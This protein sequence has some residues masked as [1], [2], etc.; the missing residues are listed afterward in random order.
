MEN[1]ITDISFRY[2]PT[3]EECTI[4]GAEISRILKLDSPQTIYDWA[5]AFSDY[6]SIKKVDGR[7]KFSKKSLDEFKFIQSLRKKDWSWKQIKEHISKRGFEFAQYDSGLIN[8]NDPMGYEALAVQISMKNEIMLQ[9]FLKTLNQ[10]LNVR[11][12]LL[13]E[14]VE[15]QMKNGLSSVVEFENNK[16]IDEVKRTREDLIESLKSTVADSQEKFL[17]EINVDKLENSIKENMDGRI[18]NLTA[19]IIKRLEEQNQTQIKI[20]EEQTKIIES[21]NKRLEQRDIDMCSVLKDNLEKQQ[22][23]YQ[24]VSEK[25]NL[26]QILRDIFSFK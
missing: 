9:N 1:K 18:E 22:E 10:S 15:E 26:F 2:V 7:W 12:Q 14:A 4:S 13:L 3:D 23:L 24:K 19:D 5:N 25:K 6:L 11:D 20:N 21:L 8:P 17:E 16:T